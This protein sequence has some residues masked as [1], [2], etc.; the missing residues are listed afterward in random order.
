MSNPLL[1]I[2]NTP[3]TAD[4]ILEKLK[5]KEYYWSI[6][7]LKLYVQLDHDVI[8]SD[9]KYSLENISRSEIILK[10]IDR[11]MGS[12]EIMPVPRIVKDMPQ[13]I[14]TSREE[15]TNAV[16]N[17]NEFELLPNNITVKRKTKNKR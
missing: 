13:S 16:K 6:E 8:L 1:E 5:E 11:I 7:Q 4:E 9:G 2:L 3:R 14:I 10:E 15:I 12:E 17:S